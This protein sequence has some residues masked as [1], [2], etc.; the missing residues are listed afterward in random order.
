MGRAPILLE[1][2]TKVRDKLFIPGA[3]LDVEYESEVSINTMLSHLTH[4]SKYRFIII[5][6]AIAMSNVSP[7]IPK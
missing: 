1:T 4:S 5:G 7:L 6:V 2:N 3:S